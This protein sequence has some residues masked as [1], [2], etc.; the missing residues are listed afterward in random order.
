MTES[1]QDKIRKALTE[2]YGGKALEDVDSARKIFEHKN[3]TQGNDAILTKVKELLNYAKTYYNNSAITTFDANSPKALTDLQNARWSAVNS[4]ERNAYEAVNSDDKLAKKTINKLFEIASKSQALDWAKKVFPNETTA[5][6]DCKDQNEIRWVASG[7]NLLRRFDNGDKTEPLLS[8]FRS[9]KTRDGVVYKALKTRIDSAIERIEV[10]NQ[11]ESQKKD[12]ITKKKAEIKDLEQK[13]TLKQAEVNAHQENLDTYISNNADKIRGGQSRVEELRLQFKNCFDIIG[14]KN[15]PGQ[16]RKEPSIKKQIDF[17]RQNILESFKLSTVSDNQ[18]ITATIPGISENLFYGLTSFVEQFAEIFTDN[19]DKNSFLLSIENSNLFSNQQDKEDIKKLINKIY[20]AN[21]SLSVD[22]AKINYPETR[23]FLTK[24]VKKQR[25]L[26]LIRNDTQIAF[27]ELGVEKKPKLIEYNDYYN[28]QITDELLAEWKKQAEFIPDF[29]RLMNRVFPQSSSSNPL[30]TKGDSN[31]LK[32]KVGLN[33]E[34]LLDKDVEELG[35]TSIS[36]P[37]APGTYFDRFYTL[38]PIDYKRKPITKKWS[39]VFNFFWQMIPATKLNET[40]VELSIENKP[41]FPIKEEKLPA[42]FT[43]ETNGPKLMKFN[44]SERRSFI[45]QSLPAYLEAVKIL[46]EGGVFK[47]R[48]DKTIDDIKFDKNWEKYVRLS[49]FRNLDNANNISREIANDKKF[50]YNNQNSNQRLCYYS[51]YSDDIKSDDYSFI[52]EPM[53]EITNDIGKKLIN[54]QAQ[55]GAYSSQI[56]IFTSNKAKAE[57]EL[58]ALQ[59]SQKKA[60][61]DLFVLQG[62]DLPTLRQKYNA[63][64]QNGSINDNPTGGKRYFAEDLDMM[65]HYMSFIKDDSKRGDNLFGLDNDFTKKDNAIQSLRTKIKT[66]DGAEQLTVLWTSYSGK[67]IQEKVAN[68]DKTIVENTVEKVRKFLEE[69]RKLV[70]LGPE[71]KTWLI[72]IYEYNLSKESDPTQKANI[73]TIINE[74][75]ADPSYSNQKPD[76]KDDEKDDKKD[77]NTTPE[78]SFIDKYIKPYGWAGVWVPTIIIGG[79]AI[80]YF[81]DNLVEWWNGPAEEEGTNED[82]KKDIKVKVK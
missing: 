27:R 10:A 63:I 72:M 76:E 45:S 30:L 13:I 24:I 16:I 40:D 66:L 14:T 38:P 37:I 34:P 68:T 47:N 54:A 48:K 78:E 58:I 43:W 41:N 21:Y 79:I 23:G 29:L 25:E 2:Q 8:S 61:V 46:L 22:N 77:D 35:Y 33:L 3:V 31:E 57:A 39:E 70:Y 12:A 52:F 74:I 81:W 64:Y 5:F 42:F 26:G 51:P 55:V 1:L 49:F 59:T 71:E 69:K 6:N 53:E 36:S 60:N 18:I 80:W 65:D 82:D 73:Q 15:K 44:F 17:I 56:G 7:L 67:S 28:S 50:E 75:K 32:K 11:S 9:I 62:M 19:V 4:D 20:S